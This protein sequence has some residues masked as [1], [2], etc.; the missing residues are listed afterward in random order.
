MSVP[1]LIVQHNR[2]RR[3]NT[4]E[5]AQPSKSMTTLTM[6]NP[7]HGHHGHPEAQTTHTPYSPTH[8]AQ[9]PLAHRRAFFTRT[10]TLPPPSAA[11]APFWCAPCGTMPAP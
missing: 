9:R 3:A 1:H 11:A 2:R 7:R 4:T 10:R 6:H 5:P 8:P